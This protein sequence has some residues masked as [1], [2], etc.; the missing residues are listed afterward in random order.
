[1]ELQVTYCIAIIVVLHKQRP[2]GADVVQQHVM[3]TSLLSFTEVKQT[4][5]IQFNL[6]TTGVTPFPP[7][8]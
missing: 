7:V 2:I 5:Y 8:L 3:T 1:M 4:I 6:F